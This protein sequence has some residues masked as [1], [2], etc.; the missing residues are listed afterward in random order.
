[1]EIGDQVF[2]RGTN[3]NGIV[4][5]IRSDSTYRDPIGVEFLWGKY[6]MGDVNFH[7]LDGM[8]PHNKGLWCS[9]NRLVQIPRPDVRVNKVS[10]LGNRSMERL[11]RRIT[12][13]PRR[14]RNDGSS[15]VINYGKPHHKVSS[16]VLC[17]NRTLMCNKF[18]QCLTMIEKGVSVPEVSLSQQDGFIQKPKFSFGGNGI[19]D[20][21]DF[22]T[23]CTGVYYHRS[24]EKAREFR[25]HVM[26]WSHTPV[27]L[28]QEKVVPDPTQLCWNR[29]Q[30]AE[31]KGVFNYLLD[32]RELDEELTASIQ[33]LAIAAV[34]AIRYDMGGVDIALATDG[35]LYVFEVNS[36]C[37]LRE[38][39]LAVYTSQFWE[40]QSIDV[41][42]YVEE[43]WQ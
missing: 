41:A 6:R 29:H 16:R 13:L 15:I 21:S 22:D 14:R 34:K 31:F 39:T 32:T 9:I 24:I 25:A 43:R 1:M 2:H 8:L 5:A 4:R 28:I 42:Q 33:E 12:L 26:L 11:I 38:R 18:K 37:G 10:L 17:I 23:S 3:C 19:F 40:L 36:R 7:S 27:Q 35:Q 20:G 30:G